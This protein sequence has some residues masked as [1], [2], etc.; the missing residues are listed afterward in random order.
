MPDFPIDITFRNMD[1]SELVERAIRE[2][3]EGLERFHPRIHYCRIAVE[4]AHHHHRKGQLYDLHITLGVPRKD[5][6]VSRTGSRNHAHEDVYVAIRDSFDAATRM[7][8]DHVRKDRGDVKEHTASLHGKVVRIFR[9]KDHGFIEIP[10]GEVYFHRNSVLEGSF[11][12]LEPGT[13]V[14]LVVDERE[15]GEGFQATTVR[16][17]GKHH[18]IE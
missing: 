8:E 3:I 18:L 12:D 9:Q 1:H 14:R 16:P 17:I 7:L 4:A 5:V 11:D 6:V 2:K 10:E 15:S 13:E